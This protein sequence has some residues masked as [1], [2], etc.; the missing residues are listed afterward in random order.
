MNHSDLKGSQRDAAAGARAGKPAIV[1]GG[2]GTRPRRVPL[3]L[4]RFEWPARN[5]SDFDTFQRCA[6]AS[7]TRT[8][9]DIQ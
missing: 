3:P 7:S 6:H 9:F 8:G 2:R 4:Q 1:E 5:T